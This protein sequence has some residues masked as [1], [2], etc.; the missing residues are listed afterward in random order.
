MDQDSR[1]EPQATRVMGEMFDDV[2]PRYRLLN[3]LMSLG[4]DGA[5]RSAMWDAV[6]ED[7]RVVLDLCTGDGSSLTGLRRPGRLVV[8]V[9]AS[10]RMLE[11]AADYHG[12]RGWAPRLVQAD[13]FRLPLRDHSVDAVT[14]AFGMRNLRPQE[15]A[16]DEIARV[17][18]A[19]GTL[20]A[21]LQRFYLRRVVPLLGR[22]SPDPSAYDYLARSIEEFGPGD[23]FTGGASRR[24][25][26]WREGRAFLFGATRLW[27]AAA[28]GAAESAMHPARLGESTRGEMPMRA[29]AG[30]LERRVAEA[31]QFVLALALAVA[32]G[33]ALAM[34][35]NPHYDIPLDAPR[36]T[37][38]LALVAGALVVFG[39]RALRIL[40]RLLRPPTRI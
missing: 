11:S 5:W 10:L 34:M 36:R 27:V 23:A 35:L 7:A 28:P 22:L 21:P 14:V 31:V 13:A 2:S 16:L 1:F 4:Q 32:L 3:R 12:D 6:P 20:V 26:V 15:R 18:S 19:G 9:D 17:M 37:L 29:R 39:A 8:G 38:L 25:F 33:V 30:A 40:I 24:G